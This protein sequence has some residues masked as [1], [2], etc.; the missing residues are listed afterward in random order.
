MPI[1]TVMF[2]LDGTLL[3]MDPEL[4]IKDYFGRIIRH[5]APHGYEAQTLID[6]LWKGTGAAI[7]N[8]GSCSNEEIF[9]SVAKDM[10]GEKIIKDKPL[11]DEFYV[12]EFDK[13]KAS[14]GFAPESA[15]I[16]AS[17]KKRGLRV[18]L[19]TNPIFPAQA[20]KWR[21]QWAGLK[22]EDF[23]LVTTYENSCHCKPNTDY[24][25]D[26][27]ARFDLKGEECIMVGNDVQEDMI[28]RTLG[29]KVFLLTPC[30]IDR[31]NEDIS[32]YPHGGY[33]ELADFLD[34]I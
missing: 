10:C 27:L 1:T 28:A 12:K 33:K 14:C 16:I 18:I 3:P 29:M 21:I 6:L 4:F 9:W 32:V 20:T 7:E 22:F 11:F 31:N 34:T 25:R 26:I 15:G 30:L 13:V 8:D 19:A 5:M 24:Y 23:D 17:L 2:D